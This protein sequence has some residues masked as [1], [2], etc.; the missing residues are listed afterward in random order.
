MHN[1]TRIICSLILIGMS[2]YI[3]YG[4]IF[5][6]GQGQ[7]AE[8]MVPFWGKFVWIDLTGTFVLLATIIFGYERDWRI[9]AAMVLLMNLLGAAAVAAWLLWRGKDLYLRLSRSADVPHGDAG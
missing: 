1:F 7:V 5:H 4:F 3:G 9:G 8:S 6:S 2:I